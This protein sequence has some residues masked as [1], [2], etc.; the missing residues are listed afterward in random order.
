[1]T[2]KV[3][4]PREV[5]IMRLIVHGAPE[6]TVAKELGICRATVKGHIRKIYRRLGVSTRAEAAYMFAKKESG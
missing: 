1:M 6:K 5:E 4:T 3:L 2:E